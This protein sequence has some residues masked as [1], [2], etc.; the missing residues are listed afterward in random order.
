M[1]MRRGTRRAGVR[2]ERAARGLLYT[3]ES[4]VPFTWFSA[5]GP[6][7]SPPGDAALRL[8]T[9]AADG[10]PVE[11]ITLDRFFARHIERV[12]PADRAAVALVPRYRHLR[13]TLRR[14]IPGIRVYR[15]GRT[16][17]RCFLVGTDRDGNLVG[18]YTE[19][20]ET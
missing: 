19:A 11:T 8:A 20:I 18:L 2:L 3:S 15:V 5:A 6:F 7:A 4:D 14:A 13:E 16:R 9:G 1:A 12:D 10:D 17:V